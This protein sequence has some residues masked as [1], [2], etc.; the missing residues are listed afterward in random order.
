MIASTRCRSQFGKYRGCLLVLAGRA[1]QGQAQV[2]AGEELLGLLAGQALVRDDGGAGRRAVRGLA[3]QHLPG[4]LAF[5]VQLGVRQAEPGDRPVAGA[6][7]QQLGIPSTSGNGWG[8]TRSPAQPYRSERFAV[9]ADWPHG[10]GVAS[11]SR[12]SSALP[13]RVIGQPPQR[14]LH[15]RRERLAAG[16]CTR[17]AQQPGEQV[18]DPAERGA[19]PVPL[20]VIAQQHLRHRQAR[21]ARRRSP[22]AACPARDR[23][24]PARGDDAVGQFH[25]ECGQE[26]V[27]VGDHGGLQGPD[28][29][30]HADPGHSSLTGHGPL[31]AC[32]RP[33]SSPATN[34]RSTI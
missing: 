27:Q 4:L 16:R 25:V 34:S 7:Q 5:A 24:K 13:G 33:G 6:D 31:A 17:L 26:S 19:Q 18:P 21:P 14:R 9:T 3:F 28:V 15:Q 32:R 20:V 12:S 10:T 29:C 30:R 22:P 8:S 2:R 11:I 23:V 1:D